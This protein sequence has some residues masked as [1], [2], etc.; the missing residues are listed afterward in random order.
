MI[1]YLDSQSAIHLCKNHVFHECITY[2]DV[3]LHFI[4]DIMSQD[5]IGLEKV[6]LYIPSDMGT[7]VLPTKFKSCL[8]LLNIGKDM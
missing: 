2:I 8:S 7:K 4:R 1:V 6:L 3:I 5:I